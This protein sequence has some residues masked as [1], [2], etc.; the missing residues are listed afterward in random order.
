ML[1]LLLF[2]MKQDAGGQE[3]ADVL[4]HEVVGVGQA[5]GAYRHG[6]RL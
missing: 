4:D 6:Q 5:V 1:L 2:I 3:V